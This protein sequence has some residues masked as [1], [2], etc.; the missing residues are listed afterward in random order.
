MRKA[1]F[2]LRIKCSLLA[3]EVCNIVPSLVLP[4]LPWKRE[5]KVLRDVSLFVDETIGANWEPFLVRKLLA[6]G[7]YFDQI[8]DHNKK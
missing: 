3:L 2:G 4:D 8:D 7:E 5:H 6:D 1:N